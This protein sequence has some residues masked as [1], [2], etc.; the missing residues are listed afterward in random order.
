MKPNQLSIQG[1]TVFTD[2]RK[3]IPMEFR[4]GDKIMMTVNKE[5]AKNGDTGYIRAIRKAQDPE[6]PGSFNL[7]A[8]VEFNDDGHVF[9]ISRDDVQDL[10]LAYCTSVHKSQGSEY[11]V[12]IM[13]MCNEHSAMLKRN[14][15]YTA[16]T[17]AKEFVLLI[18]ETSAITN[19]ILDTHTK[20]R[21]TLLADR[22][23]GMQQRRMSIPPS[24]NKN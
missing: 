20:Q 9:T 18:G 7:V 8:D 2:N 1:K 13:V 17:R 10:D 11:K 14:L 24:R 12:V 15:F 19:A 6:T 21:Y 22:L 23:H 16:I 3:S 4:A 5:W